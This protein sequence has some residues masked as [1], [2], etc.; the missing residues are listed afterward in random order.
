L[1]VPVVDVDAPRRMIDD[2]DELPEVVQR[3]QEV[4]LERRITERRPRKVG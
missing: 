1:K 2:S 3:L 4:L